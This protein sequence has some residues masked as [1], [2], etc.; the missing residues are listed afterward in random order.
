V[1]IF[2]CDTQNN[3]VQTAVSTVHMLVKDYLVLLVT[4]ALTATIVCLDAVTVY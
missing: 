2:C 1:D 3:T 4:C